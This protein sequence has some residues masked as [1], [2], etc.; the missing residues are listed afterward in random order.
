[1]KKKVITISLIAL[2]SIGLWISVALSQDYIVT[3][4]M[5]VKYS[6]LP[7]NYSIGSTTVDEVYLQIKGKGWELAKLDLARHVEYNIPVHKRIGHHKNNLGDFIEANSWIRNTFQVLDIAPNQVEY[8]VEKTGTKIVKVGKNINLLFKPGYGIVSKVN[9]S[10]ETIEISGPSQLLQKIDT[11]KTQ[12]ITLDNIGDNISA[13]I[14]LEEINGVTV[15]PKNCTVKFEV[16]KI[17][18]KTFEGI[19]VEARSVP[20]SKELVLYPGKINVVL[21][22]GINTL[23]KLS[24]DSIKAYIDYWS[25]LKENSGLIEPVIEIPKFTVISDIQPKKIEYIIKQH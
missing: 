2:F 24:N 19:E 17:V 6:D 3:V 18:D 1:M 22:G 25:A 12:F 23:G 11:V 5:P 16:Q 15:S 14:P 4:N 20:Y 9:I 10:P 13:E 21:R 7:T 8:D